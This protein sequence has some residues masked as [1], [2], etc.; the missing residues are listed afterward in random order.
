MLLTQGS[1]CG[2]HGVLE[3]GKV[4]MFGIGA[5]AGIQA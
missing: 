4:A 5:Q 2:L 3:A 1:P